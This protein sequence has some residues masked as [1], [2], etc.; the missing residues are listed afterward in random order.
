[1]EMKIAT[2]SI[3]LCLLKVKHWLRW[4]GSWPFSQLSA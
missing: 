2:F 4:K 1:M 3:K